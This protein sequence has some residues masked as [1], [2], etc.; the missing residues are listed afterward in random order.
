[1]NER[2]ESSSWIDSRVVVTQD[3]QLET[4]WSSAMSFDL[5]PEELRILGVLIEKSLTQPAYY[6]MTINA[7]VNACN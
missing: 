3:S 1:M 2:V 4:Q 6:P 5:K 7:I